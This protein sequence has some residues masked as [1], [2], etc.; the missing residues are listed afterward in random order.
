[1]GRI[2]RSEASKKR[3]DRE[4]V[5][6]QLAEAKADYRHLY[7]TWERLKDLNGPP[8]PTIRGVAINHKVSYAS[9]RR[10]LD[11]GY[12]SIDDFN[13]QKTKIPLAQE[14]TIVDWCISVAQQNLP[15]DRQL[16]HEYASSVLH[17]TNP[18]AKLGVTWADRFLT[19]HQ[20]KISRQWSHPRDRSRAI[21]TTQEAADGYFDAYKSIV[22]ENG[23]KIP[24]HRQFAF[25]ETGQM[26][27]S[28]QPRRCI[29]GRDVARQARNK[30]DSRELITYVPLISGDGKLVES[31]VIFPAK[32][33]KKDWF[34]KNPN[35]FAYV[36]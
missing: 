3:T 15:M 14:L 31:L 19:R 6:K 8:K 1:M 25:D 16:L 4:K 21:C 32:G 34:R 35:K 10:S 5:Q 13:A 23:E 28:N 33:W 36:S 24:A 29:V 9:L 7:D 22:G 20:N 2:A 17:T 18:K 11:E 12:I 30:G 27:G 26:R